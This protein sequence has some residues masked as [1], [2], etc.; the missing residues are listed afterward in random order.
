MNFKIAMR[1]HGFDLRVDGE[2]V[3]EDLDEVFLTSHGALTLAIL[4][5]Q[6]A[7]PLGAAEDAAR[8]IAKCLPGARAV[9]VH[10][11]LVTTA[12][13]AHR[14]SVAAEAVRLWANGRRRQHVR[15]FPA[16]RQVIGTSGAKSMNLY[17]WR[18]VLIWTREVI[19]IDPDEDVDYLNDAQMLDLNQ[20]LQHA[21]AWTPVTLETNAVTGA[22]TFTAASAGAYSALD[23]LAAAMPHRPIAAANQVVAVP[24]RRVGS[25]L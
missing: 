10:D 18:E 23:H 13:I 5:T 9:E 14:C 17:A 6:D 12:D 8:R 22:N 4:F 25:T 19:G 3:P 24:P 20:Y 21:A 1:L 11:E 16:P 2:A 7:D 15:K